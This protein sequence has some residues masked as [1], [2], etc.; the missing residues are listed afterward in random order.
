MQRFWHLT[1]GIWQVACECL[2]LPTRMDSSKIFCSKENLKITCK[3]LHS[4]SLLHRHLEVSVELKFHFYWFILA[5]IYWVFSYML[6]FMLSN[7]PSL[8]NQKFSVMYHTIPFHTQRVPKVKS[9]HRSTDSRAWDFINRILTS[10]IERPNPEN[11]EENS[12]LWSSKFHQEP[13]EDF[14]C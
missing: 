12:C 3:F 5:N 10:L 7:L 1:G 13:R 6:G 9:E 14:I 2:F 4:L 11:S 8:F